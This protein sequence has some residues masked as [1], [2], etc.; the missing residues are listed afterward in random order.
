M[1]SGCVC[2]RRISL[3]GDGNVLYPVFS[4]S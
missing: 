4:S 1:L 3:N 2:V